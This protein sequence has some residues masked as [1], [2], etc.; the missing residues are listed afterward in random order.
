MT[1]RQSELFPELP[2][3]KKYVSDYPELVAEWHPT[4]NGNLLPEDI[5]HKV[6][7]RLWWQCSLGHE[8]QASPNNRAK[9]KKCPYCSKRLIGSDNNLAVML[10]KVAKEWHPSKNKLPATEV[11]PKSGEKAWW[12][13]SKGHEWQA[14]ISSRSDS[15]GNIKHRCPY[16]MGK[17]ATKEHNLALSFPSLVSEWHPTK[18][19]LNPEDYLPSSHFK[20]W[21]QCKKL[22]E[23]QTAINNRT[24]GTGCPFCSGQSSRPEIR[25]LTEL[26]SIFDG[27]KSRFKISGREVD[28]FIPEINTAIEYDGCYWHGDKHEQDLKKQEIIEAANIRL[29][30]LR[31][32]PLEPI[33]DYDI[34]VHPTKPLEKSDINKLMRLLLERDSRIKHYIDA[35]EFQ[36]DELFRVYCNNFPSPLPEHSLAIQNPELAKEWHL[37]KNDPLTPSNFTGNSG[38]KVWWLCD[39]NHSFE[40]TID[41]RN[42]KRGGSG[43]PYCSNHFKLASPEYNMS[44]THPHLIPFF[45]PTKNRDTTPNQVT[46]GADRILWWRCPKNPDHEWEYSANHMS[47]SKAKELCPFCRG[48]LISEEN[49]MATTHPK[50]ANLFHPYKNGT[51]S[52]HN[53]RTGT[54]KMIWW[55]CV[56]GHE[57]QQT[58]IN[59]K[60]STGDELCPQCKS[61]AFKCPEIALMWHP[62]LN[63]SL[64]TKNISF[65]SGKKVWWQCTINESHEWYASP[66]QMSDTRRNGYCPHCRKEKLSK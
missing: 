64:S 1:K 23:W 15:Q 54:S 13:C 28:I 37:T 66:D 51:L 21:W 47:S 3:D 46:G 65:R 49:S 11:A 55:R 62:V 39:K 17:K 8:W 63:G 9:G 6:N 61:L 25:I 40:A 52:P 2:S 20:V 19:K 41:H 24:R 58:G 50:I 38:Q 31:E 56:H 12:L 33:S 5:P 7:Y 44:V 14:L 26:A 34:I 53:L 22:H 29:I 36:N 18:N 43:C 4:K 45:H 42:A 35:D 10:P 16:C 60:R 59:L 32:K 48:T 30:R 27:V 57:W